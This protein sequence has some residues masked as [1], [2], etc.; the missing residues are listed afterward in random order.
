MK[1]YFTLVLFILTAAVTRAQDGAYLIPRHIYVGDPAVLIVP[2]P[3]STG[4]SGDDVLAAEFP[5]DANI[6][7]HRIIIERRP[8]GG[9]LLIEFTAFVPGIL[10]LPAFEIGGEI[11]SGLSVTVNS[12]LDSGSAPVLSGPAS[13]LAMP[14]TALLLYISMAVFVLL[15]LLTIWFLLKGRVFLRKL[16]KKWKRRMLFSSMKKTEKRLHKAVLKGAEKR[17]ILDEISLGFREFLCGLTGNNCLSMTAA[18]FERLPAGQFSPPDFSL[19][20]LGNFFRGCDKLR[21]SGTDVSS[22]DILRLLDDLRLFLASLENG[23]KAGAA[24]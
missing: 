18:E 1:K 5:S 4:N 7:F 12:L 24:A 2:L 15:L 16:G 10:Q 14:G 13:S 19:L 11:F 23:D 8:S 22:Q 3:P 6:D 17:V 20:S 9:R 21:F